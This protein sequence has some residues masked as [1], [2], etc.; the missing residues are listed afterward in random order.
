MERMTGFAG[1]HLPLS[2]CSVQ[3]AGVGLSGLRSPS[4]LSG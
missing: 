2:L 1:Q 4:V 3:K